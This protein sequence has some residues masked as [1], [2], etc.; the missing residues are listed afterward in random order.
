MSGHGQ[1]ANYFL[2]LILR[3][4]GK[5]RKFFILTL[6][7]V[8]RFAIVLLIPVSS[9]SLYPSPSCFT[10]L[11][12]G[13]SAA[14]GVGAFG[15]A[16]GGTRREEDYENFTY[17]C[18][19]LMFHIYTNTGSFFF[20]CSIW[21]TKVLHMWSKCLIVISNFTSA[22]IICSHQIRLNSLVTQPVLKFVT[23]FPH[24]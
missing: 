8:S 14:A 5:L 21:Q 2:T 19:T 11:G 1:Y 4:S 7:S 24:S 3:N 15:T 17:L 20:Y 16:G 22:S 18:E 10:M 13:G 6:D 23:L 9:I 12:F